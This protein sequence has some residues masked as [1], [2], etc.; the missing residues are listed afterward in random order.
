MARDGQG[1]CS[2]CHSSFEYQLIHNG[3]NDTA[4]AYC[5]TCGSTALLSCWY[6]RSP[7]GS[8]LTVHG[9]ISAEVEPLLMS[10]SCGGRFKGDAVPRCPSCRAT[11]SP[12]EARRYIEADHTEGVRKGWRWQGNWHGTYCVIVAGR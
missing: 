2:A 10:C 12:I 3:F 1:E 11:L 5:D 6:P 4:Y 7:P 8:G 9:P